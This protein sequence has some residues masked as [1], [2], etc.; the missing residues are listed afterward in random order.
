VSKDS[1][2]RS[3]HFFHLVG[4]EDFPS[5][6]ISIIV[7]QGLRGIKICTSRFGAASWF[8]KSTTFTKN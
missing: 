3:A 2:A 1:L 8:Y 6:D 4:Y 7:A 5:Q